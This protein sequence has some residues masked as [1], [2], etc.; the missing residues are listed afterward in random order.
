MKKILFHTIVLVGLVLLSS[1]TDE[2]LVTAPYQPPTWSK[3][4]YP[5][6]QWSMVSPEKYGYKA[7]TRDTLDAYLN[8]GSNAVTGIVVVVGGEMIYSWGTD[9]ELSYLASARKSLLSMLYGKYV[10]D[11]TIDLS[12]TIGELIS[13]G[14]IP[15][16]VG[17]LLP[18]EKEATIGHCIA[19]RSG[20]YHLGSNEGDDRAIAPARGSQIPGTYFL[21]NNWDF[22]VSGSIFE[23]L[24]GKN[25]YDAL[26]AELAV[27]IGM[28]DWNRLRQVKGGSSA[29][30]V[31]PAYHFYLS[32]RDM[33]RLGYLMLRGGKWNGVQLVP[34]AWCVESTAAYTPVSEM[35]PVT[36]RTQ[37][38]G[39]GYMWWVWDGNANRDAFKG[40]YTAKGAGGQYIAVLPALDMVVAQ[41][42]DANILTASYSENSFLGFLRLIASQ[43][44][45]TNYV[46]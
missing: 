15:D 1:C 29:I 40:A 43:Q 26:G 16:D 2:K 46:K 4:F 42:R 22:N 39:Y 30:S 36:A 9:N 3:D 31:Y 11:G 44:I 27:P 23:S 18:I 6:A 32:A 45:E 35:T 17:G 41:K 7:N 14:V 21:Y 34:A 13:N 38:F 25:I 28:Q 12:R 24:T 33:A 19:A 5:G 37:S 8:V 20:V 10:T